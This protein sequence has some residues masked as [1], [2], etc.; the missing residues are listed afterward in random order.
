MEK[1]KK[2]KGDSAGA[3]LKECLFLE[4]KL[5]CVFDSVPPK[6]KSKLRSTGD[7][8]NFKFTRLTALSGLTGS[9]RNPL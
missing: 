6:K 3:S 7:Y 4:M 1:S 9:I 2:L 8:L 5:K